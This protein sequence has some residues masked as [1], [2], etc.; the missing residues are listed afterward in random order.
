ML[1]GIDV[2][3]GGNAVTN[4]AL[5]LHELAT[6]AAKYGALSN[7]TG[8]IQID[9]SMDNGALLLVWTERGGPAID[10]QPDSE[11]FG[12][13]L[14]RRIVSSHF[15]G[16][17]SKEWTP[18][19]FGGSPVGARRPARHLAKFL[20]STC[21]PNVAKLARSSAELSNGAVFASGRR[22]RCQ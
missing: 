18:R 3:I 1:N 15:G 21:S 13:V 14:S 2:P 10:G 22:W 16:E 12:G 11:G 17:M 19:R 20:L 9:C 8:A 7:E 6:N 5:L 4:L